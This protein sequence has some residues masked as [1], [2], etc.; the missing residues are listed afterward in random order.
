MK[1]RD[2]IESTISLYK[3]NKKSPSIKSMD[4]RKSM[5]SKSPSMKSMDSFKSIKD[6]NGYGPYFLGYDLRKGGR[7]YVNKK[8]IFD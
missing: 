8:N 6:D 7:L 1:K 3:N 2:S 4:S 5:D